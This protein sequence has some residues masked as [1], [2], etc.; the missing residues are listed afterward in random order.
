[1]LSPPARFE[2]NSLPQTKTIHVASPTGRRERTIVSL[3]WQ[4]AEIPHTDP[5]GLSL[6][7]A[8]RVFFKLRRR[9]ERA[10]ISHFDSARFSSAKS[11]EIP[12]HV[13]GRSSRCD[14][15]FGTACTSKS[16]LLAGHLATSRLPWTGMA[17]ENWCD[18]RASPGRYGYEGQGCGSGCRQWKVSRA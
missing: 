4:C 1:M 18:F 15:N 9:P 11:I 13:F 8:G 17:S 2:D 7:T 5:C 6:S 10:S 12:M 3:N 14:L 16:L